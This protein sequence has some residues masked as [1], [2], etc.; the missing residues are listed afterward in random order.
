MAANKYN[1]GD[2]VF[3][4][5]SARIGFLESYRVNKV[6]QYDTGI[7]RYEIIISAKPPSISQTVGDRITLKSGEIIVF[8]EYE[9]ITMCDALDLAI[10]SV[11]SRLDELRRTKATYCRSEGS[12]TG[13]A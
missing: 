8:E 10:T 2:M 7:W 12:G 6:I 1:V 4:S 13:S 5:E 9:L 11:Q 3:L